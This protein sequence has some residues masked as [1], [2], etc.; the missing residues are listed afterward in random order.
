MSIDRFQHQLLFALAVKYAQDDATYVFLDALYREFRFSFREELLNSLVTRWEDEGLVDVSRTLDGGVQAIVVASRYAEVLQRC[1]QWL[2]GSELHID[3]KKEEV[4]ADAD[5]TGDVPLLDG[6]KWLTIDNSV[7]DW[8]SGKTWIAEQ[9]LVPEASGK[10]SK[11]V[12]IDWTKWGTILAGL[13]IIVS[14]I[15]EVAF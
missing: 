15:L 13:A 10:A 12:T 9:N 14:I 2:G 11:H 6:W 1:A 7:P 8:A 4:V 5:V 3:A